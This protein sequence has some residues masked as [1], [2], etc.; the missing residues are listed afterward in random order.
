MRLGVLFTA[1][2]LT[3]GV[4]PIAGQDAGTTEVALFTQVGTA[5]EV[6]GLESSSWG[7]GGLIGYYLVDNLALE[8]AS[9]LSFTEDAAPRTG[10]G[11][12]I[13]IRGRAIYSFPVRERARPFLGVGAVRNV[14]T[15]VVDGGDWGVSGLAGLKLYITESVA[16]RT[17]MSYDRV[18]APFN[19]GATVGTETV[20]RHDNWMVTGGFS[21]G[22]G[23]TPR[24]A[25]QDGVADRE[26]DCLATPFGVSVDATGCRMD[27]DGDSVFDEADRCAGTPS[28]VAVDRTGCRVDT[29][30]DGVFDEEDR[31]ASTPA[32][33]SVDAAGCRLDTDADGVYDEDDR[34]AATPAGAQV[35]ARGCRRDGDADGVYDEDDACP[36]S[37]RGSEVNERGCPVLF[38]ADE[39]SL[40]LEG[41]NFET[42]S[43]QLTPEAMTVLDRVATA[44]NDNPDVRVRV[45]GHTDASGSR[46]F[47][48]QLSQSRAEAVAAYLA[49][50]GVSAGRMEA[51]GVGPDRPI[52][53]N[54]TPEGRRTNRRVELE[55]IN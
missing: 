33:A 54:S 32:G 50:R 22:F 8:A 5:D 45:I 39:T 19:E 44:L 51:T 15:G 11:K 23:G 30:G 3:L 1:A 49:T 43:A 16:F 17:D 2:L 4:G 38:E 10:T 36:A 31:C 27:S 53:D 24:D 47:N 35:D 12:W 41:V 26:D 25:D 29:D 13:P 46:A 21:F 6:S 14:Y 28:G 42:S 34:C 48:V 37:S 9:G 52:A 20:N 7:L 40:V 55:R 18:W